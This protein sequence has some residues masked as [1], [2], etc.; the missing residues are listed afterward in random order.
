M[1]RTCFVY[2]KVERAGLRLDDQS[3]LVSR[4]PATV[5]SAKGR[6]AAFHFL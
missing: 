3:N 4:E 6:N 2:L 1:P 5:S